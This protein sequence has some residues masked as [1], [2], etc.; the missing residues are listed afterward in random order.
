MTAALERWKQLP[1]IMRRWGLV[2]DGQILDSPQSCVVFVRRGAEPAVVKIRLDEA[3]VD[4]EERHAAAAFRH[5]DGGGA[6]RLLAADGEVLL[7]ER[8]DPGIPA[9][10]RVHAGFDDEA[11]FAV[12]GVIEALHRKPAPNLPLPRVEDWAL[13]FDRYLADHAGA[14]GPEPPVQL[15]LIERAR[16]V[17]GELAATQ[18]PPVLL[19]GDLHHDNVIYSRA[20]GWLAIDP[21]GVIGER[22]YETGAMLRNPSGD[23]QRMAD[24]RVIL[25][26]VRLLADRLDIDPPRILG[27]GFAQAVLAGIWAAE[28]G[29]DPSRPLEIAKTMRA[30]I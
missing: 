29:E 21:K 27:W 13:G 20:R 8:A 12:A 25:R 5:Y 16:K 19:H 22:A 15:A 17:F 4:G 14:G 18:G 1:D 6:V 26:R 3:E 7:L 30:L 28:D 11:T 2:S 10:E 9:S 23:I 24:A